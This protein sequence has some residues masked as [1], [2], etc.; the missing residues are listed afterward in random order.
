MAMNA[1]FIARDTLLR[2][3]HL[4]PDS[5]PPEWR[6]APATLEATRSLADEDTLVFLFAPPMPARARAARR[7]RAGLQRWSPR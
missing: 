4:A 5:P 7:V 3:S 6:L 2:D 1:V